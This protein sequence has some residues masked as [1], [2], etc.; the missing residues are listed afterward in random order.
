VWNH[1]TESNFDD[2]TQSL[3]VVRCTVAEFVGSVEIFIKLP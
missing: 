2:Q 3:A 1:F